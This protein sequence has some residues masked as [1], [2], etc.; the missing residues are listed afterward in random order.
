MIGCPVER[1]RRGPWGHI[2]DDPVASQ[3]CLFRLGSLAELPDLVR[4]H[5]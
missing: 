1:A 2:L 5:T 4:T 3:Q